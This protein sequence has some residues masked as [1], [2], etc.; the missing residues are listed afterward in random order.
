MD[1]RVEECIARLERFMQTVDDAMAVPREAGAFM[2]A[3][4]RAS[5]AQRAVEIGTSYGYSGLWIASAL[6]ENGGRLLTIDRHARKTASARTTFEAAGLVSVV[7]LRTGEAVDVLP[8]L[9]GPIDFAL[10]D[11]DKENCRK[12]V[13]TLANKMS[14][15]GVIL[16][17]NTITHADQLA[18]FVAWVRGL[19]GFFSTRVPVGNGME[20]TV[21]LGLGGEDQ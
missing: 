20:M 4:I 13:E 19:E 10:N 11:A 17:D 2:H 9:D 15:R 7:E 3:L 21:N 16:T 6:A 8:T 12:Y 14:N 18:G 1:Q 5:G